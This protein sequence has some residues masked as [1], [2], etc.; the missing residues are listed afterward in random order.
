MF[1]D[2]QDRS[3]FLRQPQHTSI[4]CYSV[5]SVVLTRSEL[6]DFQAAHSF[7]A[8]RNAPPFTC[9]PVYGVILSLCRIPP[10][11]AWTGTS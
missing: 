9:Y 4:D 5:R 7:F 6:F 2:V 8:S 11:G 10:R 1:F 3:F